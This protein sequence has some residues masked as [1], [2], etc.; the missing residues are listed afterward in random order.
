MNASHLKANYVNEY[1]FHAVYD[2]WRYSQRL[3]WTN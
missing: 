3:P 2:L 1:S